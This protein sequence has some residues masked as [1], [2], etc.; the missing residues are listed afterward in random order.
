[1]QVP[2]AQGDYIFALLDRRRC[3]KMDRL[4]F[5]IR[6]RQNQ[7]HIGQFIFSIQ[8]PGT[9]KSVVEEN[10][11][12]FIL[13]NPSRSGEDPG[14]RSHGG[15][16]HAAHHMFTL[17]IGSGNTDQLRHDLCCRFRDV[18][19]IAFDRIVDHAVFIRTDCRRTVCDLRFQI[20]IADR[21]KQVPCQQRS[22]S[23]YDPL[24]HPASHLLL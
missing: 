12:F 8:F 17:I 10:G 1:M 7:G 2:A 11:E 5:K 23:C 6:M 21:Q 20:A 16:D 14:I 19:R 15:I 13:R 3:A 22:C 24:F 4:G 18:G 9:G